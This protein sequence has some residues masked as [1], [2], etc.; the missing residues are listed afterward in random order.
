VPLE[1]Y[2]A[3]VLAPMWVMLWSTSMRN[4]SSRFQ[5]ILTGIAALA[6]TLLQLYIDRCVVH[7]LL[8]VHVERQKFLA[9]AR[10]PGVY[11]PFSLCDHLNCLQLYFNVL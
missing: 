4:C 9:P 7:V 11:L 3:V 8:P 6:M 10:G 2:H 5:A 1:L